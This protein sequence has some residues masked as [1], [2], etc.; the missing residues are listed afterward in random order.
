MRSTLDIMADL[1][2]NKPVTFEELRLA[3]LVQS[4]LLQQYQH[5][6]KNLIEGGASMR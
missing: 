6:V 5:H 1:K 2:D 3:S 4:F